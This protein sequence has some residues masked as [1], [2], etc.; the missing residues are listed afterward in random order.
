MPELPEVETVKSGL[1]KVI[2]GKK[3]FMLKFYRKD[4]RE[5]IP[6]SLI[7]KILIGE[8]ISSLKRRSKYILLE[9][10]KGTVISHLGM[11]GAFL[12]RKSPKPEMDHTHF[13]M[14]FQDSSMEKVY[15]H[16][17]D[18]RRFGRLSATTNDPF[19]HD[20]LRGLGPE[21]LELSAEEL[22]DHLYKKSRK[23]V[24]SVK[25]FIMD[26]KVLVGVGNI[27]A[28]ESLFKSG[29]SPLR[30]SGKLSKLKYYQLSREIIKTLDMAIEQGGTTVKDFQ[31]ANGGT[32]YF[33]L[34]L[35]VYGRQG[36]SCFQCSNPIHQI[37]QSGRSTWYCKNCQK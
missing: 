28:C 29:I 33:A 27:Y 15:L 34:S 13:V 30:A 16:Y 25:S 3:A 32:G 37:R 17:V 18:P 35:K 24:A 5:K 1:A 26:A 4:L 8:T 14:G 7:R 36:L 2:H 21:P 22:G 19:E 11:T 12:T 31:N 20:Y 10:A 6:Q 9:T 23:R